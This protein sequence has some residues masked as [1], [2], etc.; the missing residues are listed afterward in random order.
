MKKGVVFHWGPEQQLAFETLWKKFCEAPMLN[1]HEG[2]DGMVVYCDAS[3]MG[4]RAILVQ[5][6]RVIVYAL[7][8]FKPHE[9]NYPTCDLEFGAVVFSLKI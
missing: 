6:G 2:V 4:F 9:A 1:L 7:R 3:I 5:R 8:Q